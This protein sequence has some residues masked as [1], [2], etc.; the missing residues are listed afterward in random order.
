MNIFHKIALQSI[1]KNRSRT[2]VTVIGVILSTTM[3]T[4]VAIFGVSLIQFLIQTE[5][6]RGGNW[7]IQFSGIPSQQAESWI[8]DPEI[9]KAVGYENVGYAVLEGAAE[10][11]RN[12]PYLFIAGFGEEAF[13]EL[14]ISMIAGRLPETSSEVLLPDHIALKAGVRLPL[15]EDLVLEVGQRLLD[16][17]ILTQCSPFQEGE[18]LVHTALK[19]Y[20]VVGTY[21]R[22]GFELH[23]SAGYT[24]ITRTDGQTQADSRTLLIALKDP[25]QVKAYGESKKGISPCQLNDALL[26]F[27]GITENRVFNMFLYSIGGVLAII[28]MVGSVFLIYNSFHISLGERVYQF[29]ILMSV[30]ATARQLLGSVLFEGFCI[31]LIGI[32]IGLLTGIGSVWALLPVVEKAFYGVISDSA[33]L[34]LAVSLPALALSAVISQITIGISAY[35]P[36][37]KAASMSVMECIRQ[38]GEIRIDAATVRTSRSAWRRYGLEGTLALKNFKRNRKRYRSVV[39]SL[40]LSVVLAVSGSAFRI[41]L[42]EISTKLL[43]QGADGDIL[44]STR[45]MPEDAF[46][47]LY[48][49]LKMVE[50]VERS[51]WQADPFY[52]C[53]MNDLPEDFLAEYREVMGDDSTG[54]TQQ[55]TL[56]AQ[57]IEDPIFYDFVEELGL[58]VEEYGGENGKVLICSLNSN[59]HTT[60]FAGSTMNLTLVSPSGEETKEISATF[61]ERY[62]L[63]MGYIQNEEDGSAYHFFMTAPLSVKSRFDALEAANGPVYLGATFWSE[64]PSWT[65]SQIQAL[66]L[67]EKAAA[68]YTLINLSAA[69]GLYRNLDFVI[70][71]FTSVFVLMITLIAIANVFNTISTNIR[72]R[73]R[74]LA[75][76]RSVGMSDQGFRNM[77]NF[78]CVFYGIQTLLYSVPIATVMAWLIYKILVSVEELDDMA[79][80]F[81]WP[82]MAL[83]IL[84]VFGIVFLTMVYATEK[85][86]KV[87]IIDALRDEMA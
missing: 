26:R 60:Y 15:D 83:S 58:P 61:Q 66:I 13:R 43:A 20:T 21:E 84:G 12:K 52:S 48:E 8:N 87:N 86:R 5:I 31:G 17:T 33:P 36:A 22:P 1:L 78:E 45:D 71:L 80:R 76:L 35:L 18:Q 73:Q 2:L 25:G 34:K 3:F 75:M 37:K 82:A 79:F 38:T 64:D 72:L 23:S 27:M 68:D 9:E 14:P 62:P 11:S 50:G 10:S 24:L 63:D 49:Q 70:D 42:K 56:E 54:P 19:T 55:I 46:L 59:E 41:T 51:T 40:T 67:E 30:G 44:F 53:I 6:A 85:I 65:L 47:R 4:S 32:P 28:I 39:L 57:F 69:F 77:M 29:G 7:H 16:D 81:P 74:E